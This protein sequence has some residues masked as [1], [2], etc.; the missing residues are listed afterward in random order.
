M[1]YE[2]LQGTGLAVMARLIEQ[3]AESAEG[4]VFIRRGR[5]GQLARDSL[6][7]NVPC[8]LRD[9]VYSG[10]LVKVAYAIEQ[11]ALDV[12]YVGESGVALHLAH[13]V[14]RIDLRE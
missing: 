3:V 5:L 14:G 13:N 6:C 2:R 9:T 1:L 10:C 7:A 12:G 4:R 8:D 11:R